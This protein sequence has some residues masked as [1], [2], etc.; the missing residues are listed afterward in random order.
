MSLDIHE[1]M[2]HTILQFQEH[3]IG[4]DKQEILGYWKNLWVAEPIIL[5]SLKKKN[6][7][8]KYVY[9]SVNRSKIHIF[10][11]LHPIFSFY[12]FQIFLVVH[13]IIQPH[14]YKKCM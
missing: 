6:V 7:D 13:A 14:L 4:N 10:M 12:R 9:T 8:A 5:V 3:K 2:V 1:H 11:N